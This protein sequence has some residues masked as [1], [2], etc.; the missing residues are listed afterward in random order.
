MLD[1]LKRLKH[2]S[3]R[4][5]KEFSKER[6]EEEAQRRKDM[7]LDYE[8]NKPSWYDQDNA[9]NSPLE[10]AWDDIDD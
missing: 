7:E 6:K 1:N 5:V 10:A 9:A 2:H 8:D 3:E 4:L